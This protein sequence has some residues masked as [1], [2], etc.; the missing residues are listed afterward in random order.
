MILKNGY[1]VLTMCDLF[2]DSNRI[3]V[4]HLI[5]KDEYRANFDLTTALSDA[6]DTDTLQPHVIE[7]NIEEILIP[8]P[9]RY[10]WRLPSTLAR[11]WQSFPC[12]N[13][14]H[15]MYHKAREH[16]VPLIPIDKVIASQ[17]PHWQKT[18]IVS[19]LINN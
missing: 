10:R 15:F 2:I 12:T 3:Q 16:Q 13:Q 18:N 19:M 8:G 4:V 1:T 11:Y 7:G 5:A 17:S 6:L 14:L 9:F